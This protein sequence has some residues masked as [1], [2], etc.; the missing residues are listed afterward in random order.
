MNNDKLVIENLKNNQN[1]LWQLFLNSIEIFTNNFPGLNALLNNLGILNS[2]LSERNL[3]DFL[4]YLEIEASG[5]RDLI[6]DLQKQVNSIKDKLSEHDI[7]ALITKTIRL[8]LNGQRA[9]KVKRF[10][11]ILSNCLTSHPEM[12]AVEK[13]TCIDFCDELNERDINALQV[14]N[15]MIR[16]NVLKIASTILK[17]YS[18]DFLKL[19]GIFISISKLQ[20]RGLIM[21]SAERVETIQNAFS[22]QSEEV[23]SEYKTLMDI[24]TEKVYEILPAGRDLCDMLTSHIINS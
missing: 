7:A 9:E 13:E 19:N 12:N 21:E 22:I 8:V 14:L 4:T 10:S 18:K 11:I 6:S 1:N 24:A 5:N 15:G 2:A 3:I 23:Q 16:G 17:D 20:S